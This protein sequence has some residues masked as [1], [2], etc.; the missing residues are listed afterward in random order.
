MKIGQFAILAGERRKN[1]QYSENLPHYRLLQAIRAGLLLG[2]ITFASGLIVDGEANSILLICS[3]LL[4]AVS[5]V[6]YRVIVFAR[7]EKLRHG[8]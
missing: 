7:E 4:L 6:L 8:R 5:S 3:A 1:I 2:L